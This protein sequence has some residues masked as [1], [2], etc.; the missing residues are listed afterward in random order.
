MS[1]LDKLDHLSHSSIS[2]YMRC[3]R[4]WGYVYAEGLRRPPGGALIRGRAVDDAATHNFEQKIESTEDLPAEEVLEVAEVA[5][6]KAVDESGGGAEVDWGSY[7]PNQAKTLD[8]TIALTRRHLEK[9]APLLQP[10]AVQK[11]LEMPIP[12]STRSLVGIIDL[13][14][15]DGRVIDIKTGSRKM[16]AGDAESDMQATSYGLLMGR[17]IDFVFARVID[18]GKNISDEL[19]PTSRT[20][21]QAD[22]FKTQIMEVNH[23]IDV[24]AFPPNP[25]GWHCSPKF[26]GFWERCQV[27][28]QPPRVN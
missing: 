7:T 17:P 25:N 28:N 18:T 10:A 8:S 4:Q 13:L 27:N 1:R 5:F 2:M 21:R 22:W 16:S 26:C 20:P 24:G 9:H 14:D 12:G 19:V 11:R 3:P 15:V 23:A 6:H